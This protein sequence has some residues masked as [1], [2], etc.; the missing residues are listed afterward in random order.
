VTG[1]VVVGT[2]FGCLTHVRCLRS[3]GFDV[4]ALVGRDAAKTKERAARVD[5]A[6]ACTSLDDALA[7][8]GVDA[9]T[10]A[11]PPDT[12]AAFVRAAVAAGKHVV[13]EKPFARDA[14]E[15]VSMHDGARDAGVVALVGNEFRFSPG[16]A[17]A[18]RAVRD[19]SVG[20]PR[21]ASFLLHIPLMA[22][23]DDEVPG[24]WSDASQGGGWLGAQ[25][26]HVVDHVSTMLGP[27]EGVS[28]AL[29]R[30]VDRPGWTAEDGYSV[31]FR[32]VAGADGV[33]QSTAA[34][35]GPFLIDNRVIGSGGTVTQMGDTVTVHT[36]QGPHP[37]D[38]P[39]DLAVLPADPPPPDLLVTAYDRLHSTG[40]DVGPYTRLF[41]RF[42]DAIDGA[43]V[44]QMDPPPATFA[45]GV[46]TMRVLDA[47]RASA[48]HGG[49]WV[50]VD[51]P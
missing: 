20:T 28:A 44:A 23:E 27:I 36:A 11:T 31:R 24:W 14:A 43:D 13:C 10:V 33:L 29:P 41:E 12:H 32:T 40:L 47:I 15:A 18:R 17:L 42:G 6:N 2:G 8:A 19:G 46:E 30:I 16:Q 5:V 37:L 26:S 50:A 4:V 7:L 49:A 3:A 34:D 9:V 48:G 21:L 38:V 25:A 35:R 22:S 39:A 51:R 45:D 1:A